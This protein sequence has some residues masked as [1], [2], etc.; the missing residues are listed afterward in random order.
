[1]RFGGSVNP[2]CILDEPYQF[3]FYDGSGVDQ[4]FLGLTQTDENEI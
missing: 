4:A 3:D 2:E 1:M